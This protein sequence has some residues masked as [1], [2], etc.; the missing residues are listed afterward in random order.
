MFTGPPDDWEIFQTAGV[1]VPTRSGLFIPDLVVIPR[2]RIDRLPPEDEPAPIPMEYALLA[3]EITSKG[4][5]GTDRKTKLRGYAHAEVPLYLLIDRFAEGEPTVMLYSEPAEGRY[6][7]LLSVPFGEK[8]ALP[9]PFDLI[10][11]TAEF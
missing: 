6:R 1:S 2:E 4:N 8:I 7:H 9:E 11:D 5:P 10:L 3:V